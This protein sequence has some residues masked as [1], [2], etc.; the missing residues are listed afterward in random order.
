MQKRLNDLEEFVEE[1]K[2]G[3]LLLLQDFDLDMVV[4]FV[5]KLTHDTVYLSHESPKN[6]NTHSQ[7]YFPTITKG[8]RAYKLHN[9]CKYTVLNP[10]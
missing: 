1:I 6:E 3:D 2:V 10:L 5:K 7:R 4:G 9:Y 8:D